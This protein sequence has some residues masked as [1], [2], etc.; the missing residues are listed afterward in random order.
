M[1]R[2]QSLAQELPYA[3]GGE[4]KLKIKKIKDKSY[5]YLNNTFVKTQKCTLKTG[6]STVPCAAAG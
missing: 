1:A 6:V 3:T 4:K 5:I 2:I